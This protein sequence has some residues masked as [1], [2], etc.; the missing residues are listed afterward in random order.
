[1][2]DIYFL[3]PAVITQIYNLTGKLAIPTGAAA[4]EAKSEIE[5]HPLTAETTTAAKKMLR[6]IQSPRHLFMIFTH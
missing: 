6:V 2:I 4:N 3:I 1:M 5:I